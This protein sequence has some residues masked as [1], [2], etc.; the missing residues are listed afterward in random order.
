MLNQEIKERMDP[1]VFS[2]SSYLAHVGLYNFAFEYCDSKLV[3]DM[4]CGVGYGSAILARKAGLV[5]GAELSLSSL[6]SNRAERHAN[7]QLVCANA[8]TPP[9]KPSSFDT[10]V[11]IETIEHV[12]AYRAFLEKCAMILKPDGA[13]VV[14][15]P[16]TIFSEP[17]KVLVKR[18]SRPANP[19][20]VKEFEAE[21]FA[22]LLREYFLDVEVFSQSYMSLRA[23]AVMVAIEISHLFLP[24]AVRRR[25]ANATHG[26]I[27][28]GM[29]ID[30]DPTSDKGDA[31]IPFR[32]NC[33]TLVAV[34][35][36]PRS[37]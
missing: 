31:V 1:D 16:N 13:F 36:R 34:C 7:L 19:F 35:R 20:H 28:K 2:R 27:G 10:V 18:Q 8:P 17:T 14:S 24:Q 26:A 22:S 9:F 29:G 11:S 33:A 4:A 23:R 37:A 32:K 6:K 25:L 3:L 12:L 5:V 30:V 15:T 21:E